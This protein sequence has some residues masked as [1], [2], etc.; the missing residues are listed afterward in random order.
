MLW[1]GLQQ[2]VVKPS[3]KRRLVQPVQMGAQQVVLDQPLMKTGAK[4]GLSEGRL[5][6]DRNPKLVEP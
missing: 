3:R 6:D 1:L 5:K 4:G 2:E